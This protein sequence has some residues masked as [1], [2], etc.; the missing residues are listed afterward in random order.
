M[1]D[2]FGSFEDADGY[3]GFSPSEHYLSTVWC[4]RMQQSRAARLDKH[5]NGV[6]GEVCCNRWRI[7]QTVPM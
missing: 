3:N 7:M 4:E 1:E 6:Q 2:E 5:V